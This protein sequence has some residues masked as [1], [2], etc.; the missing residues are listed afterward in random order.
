MLKTIHAAALVT[1]A[2]LCVAGCTTTTPGTAQN[3]GVANMLASSM[4]G[5]V[6]QNGQ[7]VPAAQTANLTPNEK[8]IMATANAVNHVNT[9]ATGVTHPLTPG[10]I[11][12][13]IAAAMQ[14]ANNANAAVNPPGFQTFPNAIGPGPFMGPGTTGVGVF[15]GPGAFIVQPSN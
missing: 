7:T 6:S 1:I 3:N 13:A 10:N 2:F 8:N 9:P 12:A 14:T 4:P 5:A 11:L 15:Q